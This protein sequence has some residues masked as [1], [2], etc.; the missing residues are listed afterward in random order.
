M[1]DPTVNGYDQAEDY[2]AFL[3]KLPSLMEHHEGKIVVFHACK[4]VALFDDLLE[5]VQYGID[6][7]GP[8]RFIAQKVEVEE[9]EV[10]SYSFAI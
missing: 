2:E 4:Q 8:S 9:P 6:E 3:A 5:A 1:E 10:L 7:F